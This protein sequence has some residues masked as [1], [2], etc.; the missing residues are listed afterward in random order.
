MNDPRLFD[1]DRWCR[2]SLREQRDTLAATLVDRLGS[3]SVVRGASIEVGPVERPYDLTA[4]LETDVGTL[5]APLWSHAR[6]VIFC[7]ASVHPANR[8]R[9]APGHALERTADSLRRRLAV[10]VRLESRGLTFSLALDAGVERTWS[11]EKSLFR[12]KTVVVREDRIAE[13]G[14]ADLRELLA[15]HYSGPA[16]RL[17]LEDGS[18]I[19]LPGGADDADGALISLC[20]SCGRWDE[21]VLERCISCGG[22]VDVVHA[23]RP[24]RR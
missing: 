24:P 20:A 4:A 19:F 16:Q 23:T 14:D 12:G 13:P 9:F 1:P 2:L 11:A 8:E 3:G 18:A 5:R 21:E 10:P 22:P 6:A 17:V 15:R 7:D